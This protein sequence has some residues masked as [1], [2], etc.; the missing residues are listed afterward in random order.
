MDKEEDDEVRIE[1]K[2]EDADEN[3]KYKV[4]MH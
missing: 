1:I 3:E 4:P 2:E